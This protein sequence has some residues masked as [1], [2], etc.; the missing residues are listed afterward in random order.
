MNIAQ[1]L[2]NIFPL[3]DTTKLTLKKNITEVSYPKGHILLRT[4]KIETNIYFVK[5]GIARA[6]AKTDDNEIIFWFG[7]EGDTVISMK[8]YVANQ[9]GYENKK[10][11]KTL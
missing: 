9:K 1:I 8:S 7:K 2:D 11:A 4:D 3:S 10:P 5:S 6:Y